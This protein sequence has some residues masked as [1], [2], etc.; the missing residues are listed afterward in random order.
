MIGVT[1]TRD[2]TVS[3]PREVMMVT[4][5]INIPLPD[6]VREGLEQVARGAGHGVAAV[7]AELLAEGIK[8][9][10]FPGIVFG[11]SASG[12]VARVAGSGV[13]VFQIADQY[14][15][16]GGDFERLR[17]GFHWLTEQDLLAALAYAEAYPEEIEER[18]RRE[19][20]WT[21]KRVWSTAPFTRPSPR[22][23]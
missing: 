23:G 3:L 17:Q 14:R 8:M 18:L 1:R 11:D 22:V 19:A 20:S 10:R 7:A 12:R 2:V 16:M 4:Q 6:D 13:E 15:A 9:R 21:P 5:A